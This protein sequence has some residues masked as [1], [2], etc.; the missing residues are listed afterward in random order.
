MTV[1]ARGRTKALDAW[2]RELLH[3]TGTHNARQGARAPRFRK[4]FLG[5][6]ERW[7][8]RR[9][10]W[11]A[12]DEAAYALG[13]LVLVSLYDRCRYGRDEGALEG[14]TLELLAR[15]PRPV[16]AVGDP[17]AYSGPWPPGLMVDVKAAC[18]AWLRADPAGHWRALGE[19]VAALW[20]RHAAGCAW[21]DGWAGFVLLR[22]AFDGLG[23]LG[24]YTSGKASVHG[25][26]AFMD[27]TKPGLPWAAAAVGWMDGFGRMLY[28]RSTRGMLSF[29]DVPLP[30]RMAAWLVV[31]AHL[32]PGVGGRAGNPAHGMTRTASE[33]LMGCIRQSAVAWNAPEVEAFLAG[34]SEAEAWRRNW[35]RIT[36]PGSVTG[37]RPG[38]RRAARAL[39]GEAHGVVEARCAALRL[40]DTSA[41]KTES[42]QATSRRRS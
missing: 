34:C 32:D 38:R 35:K 23:L 40:A 6:C 28:Q 24:L 27:R 15:A 42:R 12:D 31:C 13:L 21:H 18:A 37:A 1:V 2:A 36:A 19:T 14:I 3:I 26:Q 17:V 8:A 39:I 9:E 33:A 11:D 7:F 30:P 20:E 5:W 41:G 25:L 22:S 10:T 4:P 16:S 29:M